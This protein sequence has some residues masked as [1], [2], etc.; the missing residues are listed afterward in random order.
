MAFPASSAAKSIIDERAAVSTMTPQDE[1]TPEAFVKLLHQFAL[2]LLQRS[3]LDEIFWLIADR[4]IA[5][6]GFDDC[7]IYLL[8][9]EKKILI[10]KAAYGPKNPEGRTI[11]DAITIPVG[12]GI[13]GSVALNAKPERIADTRVDPRYIIDDDFRLSELAVPIMLN[14][15]CIGV[16]DTENSKAEFYTQ[17]HEEWLTTIAS[18]AATKISDANRAEELNKT[19]KKLESTRKK[20]DKQAKQLKRATKNAKLANQAK[21]EFLATISHELRTP[22]NGV[23]GMTELLLDTTLDSTQLEYTQAV[24][25]SAASLLNIINQVLDFSRIEADAIELDLNP[26]CLDQ[27]IKETLAI[28]KIQGRISGIVIKYR[29]AADVPLNLIGDAERIKQILVNL[30]GNSLKFTSVG[31]INLNVDRETETQDGNLKLKFEVRDTGIGL[32]EKDTDK[33]FAAFTQADMS[34]TRHYGGTGLGLAISQELATIMNGR[35]WCKNN[36]PSGCSFFFTIELEEELVSPKPNH[37]EHSSAPA[38]ESIPVVQPLRNRKQTLNV[39]LAEDSPVNQTLMMNLLGKWGHNVVV[40]NTGLEAIHLWQSN[41]QRFDLILMDVLMPACDGLQATKRIRKLETSLN[42]RVPIIAL[43][44]QALAGDR[45]A[46]L[47][48]GM[49]AYV[50]KPIS[51]TKLHTLMKRYT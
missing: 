48:A 2:D 42:E 41:E 43:T 17:R 18:I 38:P 7:V 5:G 50:S 31:S 22:M 25:A 12:E 49:D 21:S 33:L 39:L 4:V 23:I 32:P 16:I 36:E 11:K 3:T 10:Q 20:L 1:L 40:A 46:C 27:L 14:G 37:A 26:F 47:E 19:I 9:H 51:K 35:I 34:S 6:I 29:I 8:D 45:D 30:L 13:V 44:A 15:S 28:F 24:K